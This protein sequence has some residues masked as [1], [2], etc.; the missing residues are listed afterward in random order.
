MQLYR[1]KMQNGLQLA[2]AAR[3]RGGDRLCDEMRAL[4]AEGIDTVVSLLEEVESEELGLAS[5]QAECE[6][7]GIRFLNFPIQDR[8]V[9]RLRPQ[10]KKFAEQ[11]VAELRRGCSVAIHCR[12]GI[13]RSALL[14]A[15]I[16]VSVGVEAEN[17]LLIIQNARG[18]SV[19]DTYEQW[20]FV[21]DFKASL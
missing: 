16:L 12:V 13:G 21:L 7:A 4:A 15:C 17:A 2:I 5:E 10:F 18:C 1:L 3:P 6:S 8:S 19:P 14:A 11:L 9:P 20:D